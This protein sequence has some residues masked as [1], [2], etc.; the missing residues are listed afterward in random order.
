M[1]G[2]L[3]LASC[4]AMIVVFGSI[5]V[6]VL[7]PV[8]RLPTAGE[9]VLG[10]DYQIAPGGKGANQALAAR[11]AGSRV[12][13]V[14]AVGNDSLAETALRLL[15]R[16]GV[17]LELVKVSDQP[18]GCAAI[19][20]DATGENLIAVASGANRDAAATQVPDQMLGSD[21][22]LV[23]QREVRDQENAA[24]IRRAR[25]R[26][27][28]IML[29]LAPAGPI[30]PARL[31][32][33]DLLVANSGEATI[34]GAAPVTVA[35][36]LRL[37]LVITFGRAGSVLYRATGGTI[38]VPA[39]AVEPLDTT[40]A[41]DTFVGVLA[42]GLDQRVPLDLAL[43]R[44]SAAAALACLAVGAQTAMPDHTAIDAAAAK[45]AG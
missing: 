43:H 17:D 25:E 7:V 38:E 31:E 14:G 40:G 1:S 45:L 5:N 34:L 24:L 10:D 35:Q 4:G 2:N 36:R 41:G 8:P 9:T 16:D 39:L 13:M 3:P 33:V 22:V 12:A 32:E 28:R 19:M 18:T 29:N 23:L 11:R 27:A 21:T 20:I 44:A 26:D 42:A 30:D 6:D 37:G 15:R